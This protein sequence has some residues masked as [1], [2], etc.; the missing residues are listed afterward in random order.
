MTIKTTK[1]HLMDHIS[2]LRDAYILEAELTQEE[3]ARMQAPTGGKEAATA[4]NVIE[5]RNQKSD[6]GKGKM[7]AQTEGDYEGAEMQPEAESKHKTV[8]IL[9]ISVG[10]TLAA[11]AVLL[12]VFFWKPKRSDLVATSEG[13]TITVAS[14]DDPTLDGRGVTIDEK[15]FPDSTFRSVISK[16]FDKDENG[17]LDKAEISKAKELN[18]GVIRSIE[19]LSQ[20]DNEA[21][22][23][24]SV[25]DD[26]KQYAASV[27]MVTPAMSSRIVKITFPSVYSL[28]GLEYLTSLEVLNCNYR[29][30]L[31]ELDLSHNPELKY[32]NCKKSNLVSLDISNNPKLETVDCSENQLKELDCSQNP[33]L[34]ELR[35]DHNELEQLNVNNAEKLS[36]LDCSANR[37]TR[38]DVS[39]LTELKDLFCIGN[40]LSELDVSRNT[41]LRKLSLSGS[42]LTELDLSRNRELT[43]LTCVN[44]GRMPVLDLDNNPEL[45]SLILTDVGVKKLEL[46]HNTK[47]TEAHLECPELTQVHFAK[48]TPVRYLNIDSPKL[49]ELDLSGITKLVS[50]TI[51]K[52]ALT[53]LDVS[54]N[55]KLISL[56][57]NS[58]QL[59][60]LDVSHNLKLETLLC[61]SNCLT[62]LDIGNNPNLQTLD[63]SHNKLKELDVSKNRKLES[64]LCMDNEL[65][66]L[67][68]EMCTKLTSLVVDTNTELH[69]VMA[70]SGIDRYEGELPHTEEDPDLLQ[71]ED[72]IYIFDKEFIRENLN[73]FGVFTLVQFDDEIDSDYWLKVINSDSRLIPK[74]GEIIFE[75]P[76]YLLKVSSTNHQ[77]D[78][79]ELG[80]IRPYS[81]YE[82]TILG[83]MR[84]RTKI[85]WEHIRYEVDGR[86]AT[87]EEFARTTD[88]AGKVILYIENGYI[89]Q[90]NFQTPM[91]VY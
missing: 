51:A 25:R 60:T 38:L 53:S 57:C 67:N 9:G 91:I 80:L 19:D 64:L 30:S 26:G 44:A 36:L 2:E 69:K 62:K 77:I 28:K 18:L 63:C 42:R 74:T 34:T 65:T 87:G 47:I 50:L 68:V 46:S 17:F 20:T 59:T 3:Q 89:V 24:A 45:E 39:G 90:I 23:D 70:N 76:I 55:A 21:Q 16:A 11:A 40:D 48:Y 8:T 61:S 35:C 14:T 13:D 54:K 79:S 32:L 22:N 41:L 75:G 10:V 73:S 43:R 27:E 33:L 86:L 12:F 88:K 29:A 49:Q 7:P 81:D 52:S 66:E 37:L 71:L 58:S 15:H 6:P 56:I 5:A 72:G 85:K 4:E 82:G 84:E 78:V 83:S 31:T 1:D